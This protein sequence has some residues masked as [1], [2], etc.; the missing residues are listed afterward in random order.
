MKKLFAL[1]ALI[2]LSTAAWAWSPW[3]SGSTKAEATASA[4]AGCEAHYGESCTIKSC[5]TKDYI[6]W[7][8]GQK[9]DYYHAPSAPSY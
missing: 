1:L 3:Y 2:S 4:L 7:C 9:A 6:W 5:Y 8:A